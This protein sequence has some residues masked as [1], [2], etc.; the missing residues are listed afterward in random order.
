MLRALKIIS[1]L[2]LYVG[3]NGESFLNQELQR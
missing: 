2:E 1:L 3:I